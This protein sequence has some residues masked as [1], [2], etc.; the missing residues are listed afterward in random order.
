MQARVHWQGEVSF[1][2]ES[3]TGHSVV[4]DGPPDHG[5]LDRG[6]RPME[7]MLMGMGGCTSFDVMTM[8]KKS[9]Q[10]VTRCE[11][12]IGRASCRERV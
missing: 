1:R 4:M 2:A 3:G 8:L 5:G 9:R 6:P 10:N 7:L 12:E 11:A